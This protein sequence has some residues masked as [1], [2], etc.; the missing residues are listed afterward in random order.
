MGMKTHNCLLLMSALCMMVAFVSQGVALGSPNW[1]LERV[2]ENTDNYTNKG[3][4][5][6]CL[7]NCTSLVGT[8]EESW[9][10]TTQVLYTLTTLLSL[11]CAL[12]YATIILFPMKDSKLYGVIWFI[13]SCQ[14][15]CVIFSTTALITYGQSATGLQPDALPG[16]TRSLYWAYYV[17]WFGDLFIVLSF[18]CLMGEIVKSLKWH[19]AKK[20]ED[21]K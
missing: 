9:L 18:M 6:V 14:I 19:C 11:V 21:M 10:I 7:I 1:I 8:G 5:E 2:L 20:Y 17:A 15:I 4:W 12:C 13:A 3:L 16:T